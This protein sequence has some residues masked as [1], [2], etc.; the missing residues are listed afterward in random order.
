MV[1]ED[2][3][4]NRPHLISAWDYNINNYQTLTIVK[5]VTSLPPSQSSTTVCVLAIEVEDP[6]MPLIFHRPK[7][8]ISRTKTITSSEASPVL[9]LPFKFLER[10]LLASPEE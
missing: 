7:G 8:L 4:I 10:P 9:Q 2:G 3:S 1:S 6:I 5:L